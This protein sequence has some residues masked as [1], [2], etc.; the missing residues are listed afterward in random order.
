MRKLR[1]RRK[2]VS[3]MIGGV[4]VLGLFL[5]ALISMVYVSQQYDQYQTQASRMS[6]YDIQ[7]S[8]E[9]LVFNP[10]GLKQLASNA[11][12]PGWGTC[13]TAYNCYNMTVTNLGGVGVQIVRIYINSTGSG[14]TTLCVFNPTQQLTAPYE[15]NQA[16]QF[17]NRGETNHVVTLALPSAVTLP[18]QT[19]PTEPASPLN[20][21]FIAT[22]MGNVF[23]FQWPFTVVPGIVTEAYS[24]GIMKVAYQS[25]SGG[26][27]YGT[28]FDSK[29]EPGA[30]AAGSGGTVGT[31][32]CHTESAEPYPAGPGYAEELTVSGLSNNN[33]W[34]VN[35]WI[36]Y[37]S[38]D[39]Y[40]ILNSVESGNTQLYLYVIIVNT[41]GADYTISGGT[42]DLTWYAANH[43]DGTLFGIY[44]GPAPGK[45]YSGSPWP[46]IRPGDFFYAIYKV[47]NSIA[48]LNNP[49]SR[50]VM[51]WGCASVTDTGTS[52]TSAEDA[53]F[54][55]G[56]ILS[57]G[58]WIRY[59]A[60]SG[61]CA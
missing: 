6:Q 17:V 54:Y 22:S 45:F 31:G 18:G 5:T 28:G 61:G 27:G 20:A 53:T 36:T 57:S 33:L 55:S 37:G 26:Y 60:T 3:T 23:T 7:K 56:N 46:T 24:Q 59:E 38:S 21:I 47:D 52:G 35:P 4:I 8:S 1:I 50:S 40:G 2:A 43:I 42:I 11:V 39:S 9:Y 48:M 25:A 10:P 44:Y 13:T 41:S 30:V 29:N 34:F 15:F 32:Y 12:V 58:F 49:P 51:F 16:G 19:N 14:C